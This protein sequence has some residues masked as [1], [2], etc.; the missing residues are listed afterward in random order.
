MYLDRLAFRST[1]K[2][3]VLNDPNIS[4]E[5]TSPN[6]FEVYESQHGIVVGDGP[7]LSQAR[8]ADFFMGSARV[9]KQ[10]EAV[11]K[12]RDSGAPAAWLLVSA[13]YCAFFACI[14]MT[15]LFDRISFSVE[16]DDIA[17]LR[18]KAVGQYH[19]QFFAGQNSNFVGMKHAG[20][21][22]FRASGARPHAVAWENARFALNTL[23]STKA[24]PE[25]VR[26]LELVSDADYSPSR[27]RNS[28]NYKYSDYYGSRGE[29][30][31]LE[32]KKLVGNPAGAS[33][34][35]GRIKGR[36]NPQEPCI[37]AVL[38]EALSAPV[39][40]ASSRGAELLRQAGA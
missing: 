25:A 12:L 1:L 7:A 30:K 27:I 11:I 5:I 21:I 33:A 31:A 38:C 10:Y 20:K 6:S 28:W 22:R 14:E 13:Y 16:E 36:I 29:A 35:L 23:Y 39:I 8:L 18:A 19:A 26:L 9:R 24:W 3:L 37:V 2:Y 17:V 15:K 40:D 34:W 4:V 32:F